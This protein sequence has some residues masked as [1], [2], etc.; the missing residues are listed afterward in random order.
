[1]R[2]FGHTADIDNNY[3]HKPGQSLHMILS[4]TVIKASWQVQDN[5]NNNKEYNISNGNNK[6]R[7]QTACIKFVGNS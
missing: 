3:K 7:N 6:N 5:N 1:M 2:H 4:L